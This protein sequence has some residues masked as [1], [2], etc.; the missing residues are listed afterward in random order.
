MKVTES[1]ATKHRQLQIEDYLQRVSAEQREYAG[2]CEPPK[3]AETDITNT[4]EQAE[5]LL[6]QILGAGG[7]DGMQV[8]ELLPFLK[9]NRNELLQSLRDSKYRPK[10]KRTGKS[11]SW[12]YQQ[13]WTDLSRRLSARP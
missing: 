8:D 12:G 6:E 10:L 4:T 1:G 3:M 13:W 9:E 2:G 11:G 5:G 7:I